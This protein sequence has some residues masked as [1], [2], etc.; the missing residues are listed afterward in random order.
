M[1][2]FSL[3]KDE[4]NKLIEISINAGRAIM[5]IYKTDFNFE[6]KSDQSPLTA[7]DLCSHE[8]ISDSLSKL[9]PK[10]P[11]LSEESLDIPMSERSSWDEYWLIDPLDGTKEFI[12]RNGEFTTN[13]AL[14]KKNR[15]VFGIIHAPCLNQTYWGGEL[16]GS[17]YLEGDLNSD[18]QKINASPKS[19]QEI[20]IVCSR[21]HPS[22]DLK[23]IL[24][25]IGDH[26]KLKKIINNNTAA[27][28]VETIMGEG[29]IKVIPDWCLKE[30][31]K[32]CDKKKILLIL[33]EVQCGI[34]R[35]GKFFA[36]EYANIKPDI[37]PI[38]KGI[39]G[40]FPIGAVLM[41][42][43]VSKAMIP[44]THG[45]TFGGNPLAMTVGNAVMDQIFKKGFLTN[46]RK[47]SNYF[48]KELNNI[49]KKYPKLIKEI[50]GKGL[51]I[52][53]QLFNDQS[54]FIQNLMD[55]KLLTI[56]AAEN[57]VRILPPLNVKKSEIDL[58]LNIIKKV[59][60]KYKI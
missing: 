58:A 41:T 52:G 1:S 20:K 35:S 12:N 26:K 32:I 56:R 38:A 43:K 8:I 14:I 53:I 44:G 42:K 48:I 19:N 9:S 59:C 4:L 5:D 16:I 2:E 34:G 23:Y 55:N 27:I 6:K 30:L 39:G 21:S 51:L 3:Y 11:I 47:I 28:M 25:M 57:V 37:V 49:K 29:G 33:D 7:A 36:Y 17:Y 45:S 15:P 13:I 10:I 22:D 46:V 40:G 24:R 31:R 50:R 18:I 54:K 60:K